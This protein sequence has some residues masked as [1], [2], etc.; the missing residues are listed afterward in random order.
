VPL[1]G[2]DTTSTSY[3]VGEVVGLFILAI[4]V[5]AVLRSGA[6]AIIKAA[7]VV[8]AAAMIVVGVKH[9]TNPNDRAAW[10]TSQGINVKAGYIAGCSKGESSRVKRCECIFDRVSSSPPYDT[11]SGFESMIV[12]LERFQRTRNIADLPPAL[13]TSIRACSR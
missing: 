10:A 11:P 5:V 9:L 4:I 8:I 2:V 12:S 7:A 3:H 13:V 6:A 1:L